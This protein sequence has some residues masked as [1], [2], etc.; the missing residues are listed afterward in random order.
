MAL[1]PYTQ[2]VGLDSLPGPTRMADTRTIDLGPSIANLG[3][4]IMQTYEPV[5]R[6]KTLRAAQKDAGSVTLTR[7]EDGNLQLP[8]AEGGGMI[9][10]QA[11]DELVR[12][13]YLTEIG[14]SFQQS[15]D[16]DMAM[17][18]VGER[19]FD[20]KD[21]IATIDARI[22]GTLEGI[23]PSIRPQV[24]ELFAREGMER[25]RAF[26]NEWSRTKRQEIV[27]GTSDIIRFN[28][29][30]MANFR[31]DNLT[32]EEATSRYVQPTLELAEKL[33]NMGMMGD[34]EAEALFMRT[35]KLSD[36][37]VRYADSL[38]YTA[39]IVP[40]IGAM[41]LEEIQLL[42]Y[43]SDGLNVEG[44]LSGL[45]Y[46][47]AGSEVV[48]P[49]LLREV[50][51]R[52]F[53][54]DPTSVERDPNHPLSR[55]N[56]GSWHNM[57]N[58]G[59]AIDSPRI[60]GMTFD[61]YVTAWKKMGFEVVEAI[62]EYK[63]P[64]PHATG[65]HWHV[66]FANTRGATKP[67][68]IEALGGVTFE[69]INGLDPQVKADLQKI[70]TDREQ[71]IRA[72]EAQRRED[73]RNQLRIEAD[74]RETARVVAAVDG[75][76]SAGVGGNWNAEERGVID[77]LFRQ[78]V[79][80]YKLGEE[81]ERARALAFVQK[82]NRL[83]GPLVNY[84]EN[85]VRSPDWQNAL[86]LYQSVG[87][88]T[89]GNGARVGDMLLG[90][91]EPRTTALLREADRMSRAGSNSKQIEVRLERLRSDEGFTSKQAQEA[92]NATI[93][94]RSYSVDRDKL[95]RDTFGLSDSTA[96]DPS[97]KKDIDAAYAA[98]LDIADR[99]PARALSLAI[100]QVQGRQQK[101]PVFRA[102]HGPSSLLRV[103]KPQEIQNFLQRE[104]DQ[105]GNP[106][107]RKINGQTPVLGKS[108]K[109]Q[110]VD[111]QMQNIGRYMVFIYAP[112]NPSNLID[113]YEID[114]GKEMGEWKRNEAP[115]VTVD[116]VEQARLKRERAA[117]EW[118]T[119]GRYGDKP[120]R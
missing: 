29:D 82:H 12:T 61:E 83:P 35:H 18:R 38:A 65:G 37:I 8:Q 4:T 53:G 118:Q 89:M 58:G 52:E 74:A 73:V 71:V 3:Q 116:Y 70:L 15:L 40:A 72:E 21:Y 25:K 59:R 1:K 106:L 99:N 66:A 78:E 84:M 19:P 31:D 115:G 94:G 47:D 24:E 64:S 57:A 103:Y 88:A 54:G 23:D 41:G 10:R 93:E 5:L 56:P 111:S 39:G 108:I 51:K 26:V 95:V 7:D 77:Q 112:D 46:E 90:A 14:S 34:L 105:D 68:E 104:T 87:D 96:I 11:F 120:G 100:N 113:A 102:G 33:K 44:K 91:L 50:Y 69:Q 6:D 86:Q 109:L 17:R 9:Y 76:N 28:L 16:E 2:Q 92:Y 22:E 117:K 75:A 97:I 119:F 80:I 79:D 114:L 45:I 13:R 62:D 49:D 63:N 81:S 42:R 36:G 20:P 27:N 101:S 48:T 55:K 60:P 30:A 32:L 107:V 67:V 110:P 85:M 43:W 98:N